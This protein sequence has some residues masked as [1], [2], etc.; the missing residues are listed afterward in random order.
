MMVQ[1]LN[2]AV[3]AL[4]VIAKSKGRI[5]IK[6]FKAVCEDYFVSE[7]QLALHFEKVIGQSWRDHKISIMKSGPQ[8]KMII[9]IAKERLR[10]NPEFYKSFFHL[11][12]GCW[13]KDKKG[14]ELVYVGFRMESTGLSK[15]YDDYMHE[16]IKSSTAE[17]VMMSWSELSEEA[18]KFYNKIHSESER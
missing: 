2:D 16:V 14:T 13:A 1:D 11:S 18:P 7:E 4:R 5:S 15:Y 12:C 6:K 10:N 17:T 9:Q 3:D 8:R